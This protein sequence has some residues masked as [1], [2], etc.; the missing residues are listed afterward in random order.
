MQPKDQQTTGIKTKRKDRPSPINILYQDPKDIAT[1]IKT[2]LIGINNFYIKRINNG[3][4]ILQTD[5]IKS[6]KI[7]KELLMKC[8]SKLYTFTAKS[9]KL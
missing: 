5:S 7:A 1:L 8:E 3:K 2:K 9:E 6:F 4:H